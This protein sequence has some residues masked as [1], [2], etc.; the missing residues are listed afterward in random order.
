MLIPKNNPAF[1][2]PLGNG[3]YEVKPG[4]YA[5]SADFGN[6][7]QD[8][9]LFQI[10]NTFPRYRKNKLTV[11]NESLEKYI[12]QSTPGLSFPVINKFILH[13]LSKEHPDYFLFDSRQLTLDC[14]LTDEKLVFNSHYE[15]D[16]ELSL[17]STK[18]PYINSWDALAMQLQEDLAI[19]Q[20]DPDGQ[21]KLV[22]LHLCAP[23]HWAATDKIGKDFLSIHQAVPGMERINQRAK[24]INL[25]TLN[26]GPF[27]RF[28][29]GLST[30][31]QLNHHPVPP[32]NTP[33]ERWYGRMFDSN[34]PELF[35]RTERQTLTGFPEHGLV[36]FTIRTYF[37]DVAELMLKQKQHLLAAI[38]TMRKATLRYKGI[39]LDKKEICDWL[40]NMISH[41][42]DEE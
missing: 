7:Q 9:Q 32:V 22:A 33:P 1:Y 39:A 41:E 24:E 6:A 16:Y 35:L 2:F 3:R 13:T 42:V 37:Y 26:K 5:F 38:T 23:N 8:S 31:T 4:F 19:M 18:L 21:G 20:V 12:C 27:V 28:A 17:L 29:W 25:A 34:K 36:L 15:L 14:K 30:D 11:R 40:K 10:D